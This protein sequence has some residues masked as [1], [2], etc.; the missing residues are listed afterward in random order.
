M[1]LT[2]PQKQIIRELIDLSIEEGF[3]TYYP[4]APIAEKYGITEPLYDQNTETGVLWAVGPHGEGW[5]FVTRDG[6]S[7][8]VS[9]SE[10]QMLANWCRPEAEPVG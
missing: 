2:V 6:R 10:H 4:L 3:G 7:A 8:A 5:V 1:P 9:Y